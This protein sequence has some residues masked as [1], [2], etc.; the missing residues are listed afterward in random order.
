LADR[1]TEVNELFNGT[2]TL[3]DEN[4]R[5]NCFH[6]T[7]ILLLSRYSDTVTIIKREDSLFTQYTGPTYCDGVRLSTSK[8]ADA[9]DTCSKILVFYHRVNIIILIAAIL[10]GR[11]AQA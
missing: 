8:M 6:T 10:N 1:D 2:I 3:T 7:S 4:A 11:I 5:T 9:F